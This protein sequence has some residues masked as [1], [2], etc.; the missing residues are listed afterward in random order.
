VPRARGSTACA[1]GSSSSGRGSSSS[2]SG[3]GSSESDDS[4]SMG[5]DSLV[6]A[7]EHPLLSPDELLQEVCSAGGEHLH[8]MHAII[9]S[10][11]SSSCMGLWGGGGVAWRH[12]IPCGPW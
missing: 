1:A 5:S 7:L 4:S 11:P 9:V 12:G 6:E 2:S 3:R 8:A 10:H